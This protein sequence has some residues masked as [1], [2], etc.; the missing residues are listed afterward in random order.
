MEH[1]SRNIVILDRDGVINEHKK[2]YVINYKQFR[3]I[4][5]SL[6]GIYK[7]YKNKFLIAIAT[8]QSCVGRRI[9]SKKVIEKI[10][11]QF[12][13]KI[14]KIGVSIYKIEVCYHHPI[15]NC[16]CRK[17]KTGLINNILQKKKYSF[18]QKW[19][20]GDNITDLIAGQK[21]GL[22]LILVKTGL[23]SATLK[24]LNQKGLNHNT[25][26]CDDLNNA[27]NLILKQKPKLQKI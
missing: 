17:P 27:A 19:I 18:N 25:Y 24:K 5:N 26:V 20:V 23:G 4:K 13:K 21:E 7:L 3:I 12:L 15:Q 22:D 14:K 1:L 16:K 2:P 11:S 10:H 8:N 6:R 9:V